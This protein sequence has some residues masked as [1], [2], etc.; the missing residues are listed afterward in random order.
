MS[1][2]NATPVI[3]VS[4][5]PRARTFYTQVLGFEVHQEAGEPDAGFGIYR[6]GAAQVFL[7]AWDG[8]EAPYDGWRAYLY[9][10]DFN[11]LVARLE[12]LDQ[13]FV[14]PRVTDYGMREIEVSDPD[15]DVLCFGQDAG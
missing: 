13:P 3:R 2:S 8:P 1:Y 14:G 6:A 12:A 15:G 5:Y 9:P 10:L 4:D 7:T 11:G